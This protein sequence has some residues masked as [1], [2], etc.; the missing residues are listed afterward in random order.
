MDAIGAPIPS[1]LAAPGGG[2]L[3]QADFLRLLTAQ[4]RNQDPLS[5]LQNEDFVAQLAQFALVGGVTESN[6]TLRRIEAAV[7]PTPGRTA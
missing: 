6:A 1:P 2:Q 5:P 4:L 3:G 7:A